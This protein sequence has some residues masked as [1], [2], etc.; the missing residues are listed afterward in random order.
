M[1]QNLVIVSLILVLLYKIRCS[2]KSD[3]VD[4]LLH[5]LRCHTKS[6]INKLECLFLWIDDDMDILFDTCVI[7][8]GREARK[9]VDQQ[10]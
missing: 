4:V 2:G 3:L 10:R 1:H 8:Y 7:F 6:G 5:F 9:L